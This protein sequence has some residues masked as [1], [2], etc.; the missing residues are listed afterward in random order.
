MR[1]KE[2]KLI[3]TFAT[4]TAAMQMEKTAKIAELEGRLIPVPTQISAGCGL[5]FCTKPEYR[6]EICN[7]LQGKN[8]GYDAFYEVLL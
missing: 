5:A 4:T 7:V 1:K 3:V 6:E 8:I 2:W